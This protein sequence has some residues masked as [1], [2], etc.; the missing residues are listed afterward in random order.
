MGHI[1]N[2]IYYYHFQRKLEYHLW[3]QMWYFYSRRQYF[4]EAGVP[5]CP[6]CLCSFLLQATMSSYLLWGVCHE[7]WVLS[8][9][10]W[11]CM[12]CNSLQ[13]ISA[14]HFERD[15][16]CGVL[17]QL[18]LFAFQPYI[19]ISQVIKITQEVAAAFPLRQS[20]GSE[21]GEELSGFSRMDEKC[22]RN[23]TFLG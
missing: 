19:T 13:N 15:T 20:Q 17:F 7:H 16:L 18:I 21:G 6:P 3:M 2:L 11:L 12:L 8:L 5:F 1:N 10:V 22:A 9:G 23:R 14:F 4:S